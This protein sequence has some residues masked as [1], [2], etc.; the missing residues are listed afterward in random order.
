M[1]QFYLSRLL[2]AWSF[3]PPCLARDYMTLDR[4]ARERGMEFVPAI[5]VDSTVTSLS[6]LEKL[7]QKIREI[8]QCFDHPHFVHLGPKVTSIL[9]KEAISSIYD[10]VPAPLEETTFILCANS[11]QASNKSSNN[12]AVLALEN[13]MVAH[14][15]FQVI[16]Y[17]LHEPNT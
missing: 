16:V 11:L 2:A 10:F 7:R 15:G 4:Y 6:D 13:S 9:G 3:S 8:L 5:D 17:G 14:Y 1:S 12:K